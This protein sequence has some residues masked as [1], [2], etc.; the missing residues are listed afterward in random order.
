MR[1]CLST[2]CF[3]CFYTTRRQFSSFTLRAHVNVNILVA[4]FEANSILLLLFFLMILYFNNRATRSRSCLFSI[5]SCSVN[6]RGFQTII[7][8]LFKFLLQTCCCLL[9][10]TNIFQRIITNSARRPP[11]YMAQCDVNRWQWNNIILFAIMHWWFFFWQS[12]KW[13]SIRCRLFINS[14]KG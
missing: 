7:S 13:K 10:Y 9:K 8:I 5:Q 6:K 3:V 12:F 1:K 14:Q 2:A 4:S 11:G